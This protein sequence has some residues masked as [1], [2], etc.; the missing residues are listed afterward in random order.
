MS[1]FDILKMPLGAEPRRQVA[2]VVLDGLGVAPP[3]SGNAITLANTPTLDKLWTQF[4]HTYLQAAG[5]NVGLPH[6]IDGN[7]EV[8]HMS[9]GAG[10]IIYQDL[11]RIDNAI[12]N[13][14]FFENAKLLKAEL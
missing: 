10:K 5:T 9:I 4:P 2:L 3:S 14:S 1:I 7:S 12:A 6:G 8:G 11:P 13:G